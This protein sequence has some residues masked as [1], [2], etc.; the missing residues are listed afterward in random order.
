[1]LSYFQ[2]GPSLEEAKLKI[3]IEKGTIVSSVSKGKHITSFECDDDQNYI[4]SL[5]KQI[6]PCRRKEMVFENQKTDTHYQKPMSEMCSVPQRQERL[7]RLGFRVSEIRKPQYHNNAIF[8]D[9]DTTGDCLQ[10]SIAAS[11]DL[12]AWDM[13]AE[14]GI[15]T[16]KLT[17]H[18]V[19]QT[20]VDSELSSKGRT[21]RA[22]K[23]NKCQNDIS[24][25]AVVLLSS[26][27][28]IR[29]NVRDHGANITETSYNSESTTRS[30]KFIGS[31]GYHS[32]DLETES[33]GN[34]ICKTSNKVQNHPGH[35]KHKRRKHV[36]KEKVP[37]N[38]KADSE[39]FTNSLTD[40]NENTVQS[41]RPREPSIPMQGHCDKI[42]QNFYSS[43]TL[44]KDPPQVNN[45]IE[46]DLEDDVFLTDDKPYNDNNNCISETMVQSAGI[47]PCSSDR[48]HA[49]LNSNYHNTNHHCDCIRA[50]NNGTSCED[51]RVDELSY[52]VQTH[53]DDVA[54]YVPDNRLTQ[55]SNNASYPKPW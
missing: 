21:K 22:N 14:T 47:V 33:S 24:G 36:K 5:W 26:E 49:I 41:C 45:F 19:C 11:T 8:T 6:K 20:E 35:R 40:S 28:E 54:N 44:G 15:N 7:K 38:A 39:Q 52:P 13:G 31:I 4:D 25:T 2:R 17:T 12:N 51:V 37:W 46:G 42:I 27:R 48:T 1:M 3:D 43:L 18:V 50:C 32:G 23:K 34:K 55:R 16:S 53:I 30:S 29:E 10:T 9:G